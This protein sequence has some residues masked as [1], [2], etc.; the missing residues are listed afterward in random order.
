M[1]CKEHIK[2]N[3]TGMSLTARAINKEKDLDIIQSWYSIRRDWQAPPDNIFPDDGVII[4]N[5][6][7]P[8]YAG[9]I[10]LPRNSNICLI[11]WIVGN[12]KMKIRKNRGIELLLI[13]LLRVAKQN[14]IIYVM[15]VFDNNLILDNEFKKL[16]FKK[17]SNCFNYLKRITWE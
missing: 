17:G 14:N 10:Y 9:W 15:S 16:G 13:T 11:D 4:E 2:P 3:Q 1:E 8:I 7:E 6:G 12:P 5:N